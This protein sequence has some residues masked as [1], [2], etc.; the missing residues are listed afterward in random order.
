MLPALPHKLLLPR[1]QVSGG[2]WGLWVVG[3]GRRAAILECAAS[4]MGLQPCLPY[5]SLHENHH[6]A[7][8]GAGGAM[9]GHPI[10]PLGSGMGF[11]SFLCP[12][13]RWD[14]GADVPRLAGTQR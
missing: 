4:A 1:G 14:E 11:R 12:P 2:C 10:T 9:V 3:G 5:G 6:K 13:G 8:A 7:P